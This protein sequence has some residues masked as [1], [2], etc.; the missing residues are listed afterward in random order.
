MVKKRERQR[1]MPGDDGQMAYWPI[2]MGGSPQEDMPPDTPPDTAHQ[3]RPVE[4]PAGDEKPDVALM[5]RHPYTAAF[6]DRTA[7]SLTALRETLIA[8]GD[9]GDVV[10]SDDRVISDWD[11]C[12][13]AVE[14]GLPL[15]IHEYAGDNVAAAVCAENLHGLNLPDHLRALCVVDLF[16]WASRGRPRKSVQNTDFSADCLI[17]LTA[18]QLSRLADCGV[19]LIEQAKRVHGSGLMEAVRAGDL[20]FATALARIK[21]VKDA[22][23][24]EMVLSGARSFDDAYRTAKAIAA[25]GLLQ[26]VKSGIRTVNEAYH[27]AQEAKAAVGESDQPQDGPPEA[28][29]TEREKDLVQHN[30]KLLKK[31]RRLEQDVG[32]LTHRLKVADAADMQEQ[33]AR[34][35]LRVSQ[36]TER[37]KQAERRA[38]RAEAEVARLHEILAA[39]V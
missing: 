36:E 14:E 28:P 33:V 22:R 10:V 15:H 32:E 39:S 38:T 27:L 7:M 9:V 31:I 2:L 5:T 11:K 37:A 13:I 26:D 34:L 17:P 16:P 23:L 24:E 12:R 25:A 1:S 3:D 20:K 30:A 8:A 6:G 19:D 4:P 29:R 21:L 18:Q 35:E